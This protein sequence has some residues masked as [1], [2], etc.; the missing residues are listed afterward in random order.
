LQI[1][2]PE[3]QSTPGLT[4]VLTDPDAPSRKDPRW[5]EFCHWIRVI[6]TSAEG[7]IDLT[8]EVGEGEGEQEIIEC[9]NPFLSQVRARV[10]RQVE[11]DI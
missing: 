11:S 10:R 3:L 1:Y 8:L 9:E 4:V 5:S 6:P 7:P 2:C